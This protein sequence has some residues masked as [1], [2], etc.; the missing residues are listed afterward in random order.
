MKSLRTLL[1]GLKEDDYNYEYFYM[2]IR[3]GICTYYRFHIP[4]K[5]ITMA[6]CTIPQRV[7]AASVTRTKTPPQVLTILSNIS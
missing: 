5:E 7:V 4:N 3:S 6:P 2:R 1:R